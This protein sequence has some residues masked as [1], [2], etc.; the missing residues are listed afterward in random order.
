MTPWMS[1]QEIA[2]ISKLLKKEDVMLEWG[3]GGST[4]TFSPLVSKYYSI[5]HVAD[6][7]EK[8]NLKI[9]ELNISSK[10]SNYLIPPDKPRTI[11]T[12]YDEFK[13]Y[14]EY[15]DD[16]SIKFDKVLIDGRARAQCAER[17]LPYLKESSIVF[18]HDFWTRP[19]YHGILEFYEEVDSIKFGQ[20]IV[21][22]KKKI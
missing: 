20:T 12:K 14:I 8:V 9:K 22:L 19:Q 17:V 16:L 15:V 13:T 2:L 1:S 11:P 3:S 5:E 6:W 21:A 10:I 18:I 7:Y 4:V